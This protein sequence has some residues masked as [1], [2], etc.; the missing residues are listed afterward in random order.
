MKNPCTAAAVIAE[1]RKWIGYLEK[2]SGEKLDSFTANAGSRNYTRFNR[3]LIG[4]KQ[5]IGAQPMEWCGAFVSC[6]FVYAFGLEAALRLLCGALY[7]YTPSGAA[8][9]RKAGRYVKRGQGRP[10]PG[11]VVFFYSSA[12]GR[13]GHTG[14]VEKVSGNYV[15]TIEGNTSGGSSLVTNG[16]GVAAKKY[17]LTSSYIDGYGRPDYAGAGTNI[18]VKALE[19]GDRLLVNGME[20][21]D[22]KALQKALIRLGFSCGSWGADGDFGDAT[23]MAV[24]AFQRAYGC[25]VDGEYGPESH[26]AMVKA[27]GKL[28]DDGGTRVRIVGGDCYVRAAPNTAGEKLCVA[29]EGAVMDYAGQ[30]A[31]NGWLAVRVGD[32]T[33]WVSG[34]YGRRVEQGSDAV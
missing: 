9:F 20:G 8:A 31:E 17:A 14:I 28:E 25:A 18:E 26:A 29:L 24:R 1:A 27:L 12:K 21:D 3:D 2:K 13:I 33:G 23:E 34:R 11:D 10:K 22:V 7:C 32:G 4:Y 5:G 16:G 19:P 30:T 15:Y 6:V